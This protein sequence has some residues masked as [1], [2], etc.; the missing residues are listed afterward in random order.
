MRP[1]AGYFDSD[2][3]AAFLLSGTFPL[4]LVS[5]SSKYT[6]AIE[7]QFSLST[8]RPVSTLSNTLIFPPQA[9]ST[10]ANAGYDS[11][12]LVWVVLVRNLSVSTATL[13]ISYF[14]SGDSNAISTLVPRFITTRPPLPP[15]PSPPP[16]PPP[17]PPPPPSPPSP[18]PPPPLGAS[19]VKCST[20]HALASAA[21]AMFLAAAL[22][23]A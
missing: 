14:P 12:Q 4:D 5:C 20:L 10:V 2:F 6:L 7:H 23:A 1:H 19:R 13:N 17:R 16:P 11:R 22:L 8:S 21:L 3:A 18:P 9:I 15:S